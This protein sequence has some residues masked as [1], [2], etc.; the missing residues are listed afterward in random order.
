MMP[1]EK[2]NL[3]LHAPNVH[4]GGG[5]A[6]LRAFAEVPGLPVRFAQLDARAKE[7]AHFHAVW[8]SSC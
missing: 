3:I 8:H 1:G 6:L 2:Y 4:F 5:L 7:K